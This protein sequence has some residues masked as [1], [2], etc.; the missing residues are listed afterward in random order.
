MKIDKV[1]LKNFRCFEDLTITFDERLTV[2]VAQNGAGK[3]AILDA[4]RVILWPYVSN[5]DLANNGSNSI[6]NNIM[7]DDVTLTI[8]NEDGNRARLLPCSL[9]AFGDCAGISEWMRYREKESD[10]SKTLDDKHT[11]EIMSQARHVQEKIRQAD[12]IE[13]NLPVFGYYGTG[14]LWSNKKRKK[15]LSKTDLTNMMIRTYGYLDCLDP[16]SSYR[17]FEERFIKVLLGHQAELIKISQKKGSVAFFEPT[18]FSGFIEVVRQSINTVLA[19]TE[20]EDID[21]DLDTSQSLVMFN[22]KTLVRLKIE[23]LSDGI[24]NM[25]GMVADIAFRCHQLNPHLG[26]RAALEAQGVVLIDEVDMHLHPRWQQLILGQLQEAFPKLQF[27]VTTHSPQVLTTIPAKQI[28]I[29]KDVTPEG[30]VDKT[31][32]VETPET[33]SYGR[34]S[35]DALAYIMDTPVR[36]PI[37]IVKKVREYEQLVRLGKEDDVATQALKA[38]LYEVGVQIPDADLALWRFLAQQGVLIRD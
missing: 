25:I 9:N 36:P 37:P 34:E 18:K 1:I 17:A 13:I 10:R 6:A 7:I 38:Y 21:L 29:I 33:S 30:N 28:R 16:A 20:Y 14:R 15:N 12:G 26:K 24:R 8:T 2:L 19:L 32:I 35:G 5:F 23:Q 27:I 31:F 4:V 22:K 3:T 11:K